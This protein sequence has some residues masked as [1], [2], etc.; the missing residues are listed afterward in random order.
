MPL[1]TLQRNTQAAAQSL[2]IEEIGP[3]QSVRFTAAFVGLPA[4]AAHFRIQALESATTAQTASV[5]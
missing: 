3:G 5:D 1:S 4:E 2:A